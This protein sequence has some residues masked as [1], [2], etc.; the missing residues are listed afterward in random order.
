MINS[1][2][3]I[4]SLELH[5][6]L[7]H[8][9]SYRNTIFILLLNHHCNKNNV[10][11]K[12]HLSNWICIINI[13]YFK[14][15]W[16]HIMEWLIADRFDHKIKHLYAINDITHVVKM[17]WFFFAFVFIIIISTVAL[18]PRIFIRCNHK[19]KRFYKFSDNVFTVISI[20]NVM[21]Q[22]ISIFIAVLVRSQ[23]MNTPF[24]FSIQ[25]L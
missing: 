10:D 2:E 13:V 1:T 20:F 5:F 18:M 21:F 8:I 6:I 4:H 16:A 15:Y 22:S 17:M 23:L 14:F 24:Y 11:V 12:P 3:S 25:S 7:K 19:V 9:T